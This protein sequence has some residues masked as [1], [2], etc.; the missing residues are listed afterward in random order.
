MILGGSREQFWIDLASISGIHHGIK[1]DFIGHDSNYTPHRL[2]ELWGGRHEP[3]GLKSATGRS[4]PA[5][6]SNPRLI[7]GGTHL[8]MG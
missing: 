6:V 1:M 2:T 4:P 3:S 5:G 8:W 7:P